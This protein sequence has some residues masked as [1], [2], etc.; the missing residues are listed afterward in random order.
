MP[1]ALQTQRLLQM[2]VE[3]TPGT[4]VPATSQIVGEWDVREDIGRDYEEHPRGV[5]GD[6][7]AG[8]DD[9]RH[10]TS[11]KLKENLT[12]EDIT[13]VLAAG[14]DDPA[15]SG[16]GP[17]VHTFAP[18]LNG[19]P[20]LKA[21]TSEWV[22]S[23]GTTKHIER[24]AAYSVCTKWKISL[25]PG[26]L[27]H[28]ESEWFA[29]KAGASTV[30]AGLSPAAGRAKI[31]SDLFGIWINDSGAAIG[32]TAIT[33]TLRTCELEVE[34]GYGPDYTLDA[35]ASLD[36][37]QLRAGR[38][39]GKIKLTIEL[40]ATAATE[41]T[42]WRGSSGKG[43]PRFIR[44]KATDGTKI[45]QLDMCIDYTSAPEFTDDDM[46]GRLLTLTGKL[47][48]DATWGKILEAV[49]TN[50]VATFS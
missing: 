20:T 49:I 16:A 28:I 9:V 24:E 26:E 22:D 32:S 1:Q 23:D 3:T 12:Y 44:L 13:R 33:G 31:D 27:A 4:A 43:L 7:H 6:V 17:Y 21:F 40:N 5:R 35:R 37:V 46:D 39:T 36:F 45:V 34:G 25:A 15:H 19:P 30:T 2:G 11:I 10:G 8:G 42:K 41:Y 50:S 29:R 18:V 47:E 48:Y 38:L 14:L